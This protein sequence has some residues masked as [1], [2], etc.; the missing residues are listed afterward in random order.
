MSLKDILSPFTVWKRTA[1]KPY[2]VKDPITERPGAPRYRG[3]HQNDM[4]TCIGCGT[5]ESICQ[6]AAIDMV[7][8]EG[9][10]TTQ[11]DSGLRPRI[12][13]GRCCWCALCVDICTTGSLTMSN[14][15]IWID[16]DPD[17][18]RFVAGAENKPWDGDEKGYKR[19]GEYRLLD[20]ERIRDVFEDFGLDPEELIEAGDEEN[21]ENGPAGK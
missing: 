4:E 12:D 9:I 14:E 5:C 3:F 1:D 11:S 21:T 19:A 13:Y 17:V 15:Y 18:F 16:S 6:N 20:P 7:P 10:D 2:T 8:V